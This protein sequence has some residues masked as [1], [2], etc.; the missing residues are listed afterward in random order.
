MTDMYLGDKAAFEAAIEATKDG[1]P[2]AID[3]TATWCPP[4]KMIGPKFEAMAGE[5]DKVTLKKVDVD[6]NADAAQAAGIAC[7]PTFKFYKGGAEVTGDKI[8]G[9]NEANI[10]ATIKK[11]QDGG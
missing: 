5:F 8:E 1:Q 7:M 10:R 9:A 11:Y 4:C 6:A 2:L 3:F